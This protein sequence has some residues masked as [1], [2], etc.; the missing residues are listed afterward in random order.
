[1]YS[2]FLAI[3]FSLLS[4]N[5]DSDLESFNTT[6]KHLETLNKP[7]PTIQFASINRGLSEQKILKTETPK[8]GEKLILGEA[9]DITGEPV[10]FEGILSDTKI[11]NL[12]LEDIENKVEKDLAE[13]ITDDKSIK[14]EFEKQTITEKLPKQEVVD[15]VDSV[16]EEEGAL[17]PDAI[18]VEDAQ[19]DV[20]TP[21]D[22]ENKE[23]EKPSEEEL[24]KK[25]KAEVGAVEQQEKQKPK[26]LE[27][28]LEKEV[29]QKP[30]IPLVPK[31]E[32]VRKEEGM[33]TKKEKTET[34]KKAEVKEVKK[35][36]VAD[37]EVEKKIEEEVR[38]KSLEE[39]K[40]IIAEIKFYNKILSED[41]QE[42][43]DN[44]IPLIVPQKKTQ[45]NFVTSNVPNELKSSFRTRGNRHIPGFLSEQEKLNMF[46]YSIYKNDTDKIR[47][48]ANYFPNINLL[49]KYG[50]TPLTYATLI[51]RHN[52]MR[53]LLF[54]GSDIDQRNDLQQT[55]LHITTKHNDLKGAAI[56][57]KNNANLNAKDGL[58]RT[59]LMHSVTNENIKITYILLESGAGVNQR[60][61]KGQTALDMAKKTNNRDIENL[62]L[63][64]GAK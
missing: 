35:E 54:E 1:M 22:V 46:F 19:E 14:E 41:F 58:E 57:I 47:S 5:V 61:H 27:K 28:K 43:S 4:N 12:P 2:V 32:V 62:L 26:E 18:K 9:V 42:E 20:I 37:K 60:D 24:I 16:K 38:T 33:D 30:S 25:I 52:A 45:R 50:E 17:K 44:K 40:Q 3:S 7:H 11:E 23:V 64:Y 34:V 53:T 6:L 21:K 48:F 55:P 36:I 15:K 59:P 51:E 39:V 49:K 29:P 56:L 10:A 31:P 8:E 13:E 63:E